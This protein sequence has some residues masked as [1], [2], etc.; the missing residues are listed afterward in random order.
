MFSLIALL[1]NTEVYERTLTACPGAII[2]KAHRVYDNR[3]EEKRKYKEAKITLKSTWQKG[4][5][6]QRKIKYN[7]RV[8]FIPGLSENG[9]DAMSLICQT[10]DMANKC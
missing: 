1:W 3:K 7:S 4:F 8:L 2:E 6:V 5:V 9:H 10:S